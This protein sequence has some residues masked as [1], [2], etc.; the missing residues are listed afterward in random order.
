MESIEIKQLVI[1][2]T[3][4]DDYGMKNILAYHFLISEVSFY[5]IL[6][7]SYCRKKWMK[8]IS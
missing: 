7:H 5:Y 3:V 8:Y 1:H 2:N 4:N 6:K